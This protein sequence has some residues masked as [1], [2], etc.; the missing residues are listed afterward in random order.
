MIRRHTNDHFDSSGTHRDS[1]LGA[2]STDFYREVV[3]SN[4]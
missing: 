4:E 1:G 2:S 3:K